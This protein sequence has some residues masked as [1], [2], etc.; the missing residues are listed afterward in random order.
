MV[1]GKRE[2]KSSLNFYRHLLSHSPWPLGHFPL[3]IQNKDLC[4]ISCHCPDMGVIHPTHPEGQGGQRQP[5]K[6]RDG[7]SHA[8]GIQVKRIQG[9][10]VSGSNNLGPHREK[11]GSEHYLVT[12]DSVEELSKL[13]ILCPHSLNLLDS[14]SL[15]AFTETMEIKSVGGKNIDPNPSG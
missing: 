12:K 2:S 1:H 4:K 5:L 10:W 6:I 7:Q 13:F 11:Q 8:Q 3:C 9:G 15:L 14:R